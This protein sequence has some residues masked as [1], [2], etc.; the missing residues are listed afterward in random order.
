MEVNLIAV[1]LATVS[2]FI[3][4]GFWYSPL[5]FGNVW[6]SAMGFNEK[7]L[8]EMKKKGVAKSYILNFIS[9]LVMAYV[10]AHILSLLKIT[11]LLESFQTAFWLWL[12]FIATISL[13]SV[14][15]EGKPLKLY[16]INTVYSL[17][18]LMTMAA[19]LTLVEL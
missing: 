4:G 18:M 5:L 8:K 2:A 7:D 6:T 3:I 16:F 14:L 17:V 13:G 1:L 15:W 19:V 9:T 12:G 11:D 10:F